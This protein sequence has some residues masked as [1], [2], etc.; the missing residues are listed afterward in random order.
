MP[1]W[2]VTLNGDRAD[3]KALADLGVGVTEEGDACVFH[4]PE[5]DALT[6]PHAVYQR[7]VEWVEV[8]NGLSRIAGRDVKGRMISVGGIVRTDGNT[9][10]T[11][12][13]PGTGELK[14]QGS[15]LGTRPFAAWV[16]L[17]A[18]EASVARAL[19]FF[20]APVT[21]FS[22]WN[23]YEVIREDAGGTKTD[24]VNKGLA[25]DP[26]IERFRG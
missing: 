16:A 10:A 3:L 5:L 17:A 13:I 25:N 21:S 14:V 15:D 22:L 7:T 1:K 11:F 12:M 24:I 8:F 9:R 18:R 6:D 2:S 19:R 4:S 23:V 20:A 26:D